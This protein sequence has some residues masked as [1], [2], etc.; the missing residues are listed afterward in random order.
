MQ[1]LIFN[2]FHHM[3]SVWGRN[4]VVQEMLTFL[5]SY[6]QY[7]RTSPLIIRGCSWKPA[8]LPVYETNKNCTYISNWTCIQIDC[9]GK[10]CILKNS[11][12]TVWNQS[13]SHMYFNRS[14][15]DR[16]FFFHSWK[17]SW[18]C[19]GLAEQRPYIK[20]SQHHVVCR[21]EITCLVQ[22]IFREKNV[23]GHSKKSSNFQRTM[24]S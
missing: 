19:F 23:L 4:K 16:Y 2:V 5:F 13:L 12:A 18:K 3:T 7:G 10:F 24:L 17:C 11:K 15:W 20:I 21:E 8:I 1:N 22:V 9:C 14:A 6:V